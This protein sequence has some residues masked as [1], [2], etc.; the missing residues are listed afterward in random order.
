MDVIDQITPRSAFALFSGF[1]AIL[2]IIIGATVGV[3]GLVMIATASQG[4]V[5]TEAILGILVFL[6]VIAVNV[7]FWAILSGLIGV[8]WISFWHRRARLEA[9]AARA[10]DRSVEF[11]SALSRRHVG[12]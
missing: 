9:A 3:F 7:A 5:I 12:A 1:G 6:A 8:A 2:G 11:T 10:W 4:H